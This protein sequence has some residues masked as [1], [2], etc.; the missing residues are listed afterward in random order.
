MNTLFALV[1]TSLVH[2]IPA[3]VSLEPGEGFFTL[4]NQTQLFVTREASIAGG[5][6]LYFTETVKPSMGINPAFS[7]SRP[8]ENAILFSLDKTLPAEGYTLSVTNRFIEICAGDDAGFFY[9]VQTLLQ[10]LPPCL[11]T[12]IQARSVHTF[13]DSRYSRSDDQGLSR[14]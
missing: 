9:G 5:A 13:P 3:P 4:N 7:K 14:F 1:M 8:L 11:S 12:G 6:A 10:L 2:L